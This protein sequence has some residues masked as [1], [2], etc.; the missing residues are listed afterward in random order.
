MRMSKI[1]VVVEEDPEDDVEV[2]DVEEDAGDVAGDNKIFMPT[3]ELEIGQKF[4][5]HSHTNCKEI[6]TSLSLHSEKYQ[7]KQNKHVHHCHTQ[8]PV[9]L[10]SRRFRWGISNASE[11]TS[12]STRA[13]RT[14]IGSMHGASH[15]SFRDR[16]ELWDWH[17]HKTH[18]KGFFYSSFHVGR[19]CSLM[20]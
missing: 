12:T 17:S 16:M 1:V 13:V 8:F 6:H 15:A 18:K 11:H 4:T 5:L 20:E 7:C 9:E 14:V 3:H 2:S 10:G 19:S